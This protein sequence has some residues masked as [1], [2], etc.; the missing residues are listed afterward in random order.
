MLMLEKQKTYL[1]HQQYHHHQIIMPDKKNKIIH[2]GQLRTSLADMVST[3]HTR[4]Q[5]NK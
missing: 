1:F 3:F 5:G 2:D 4:G